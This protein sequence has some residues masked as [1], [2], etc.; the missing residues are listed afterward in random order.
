MMFRPKPLFINAFILSSLAASVY[1]GWRVADAAWPSPWLGTLLACMAPLFFFMRLFLL[2]TPRTSRNLAP[3]LI[4]GVM[5][6][7]LAL[8]WGGPF[9]ASVAALVGIGGSLA[10][11][12]W[13][14]RFE[15]AVA[16]PLRV[17]GSLPE[18][19]LYDV[20]GQEIAARSLL[21]RPALWLF[22]RGNWCPF[23]MAQVR[24]IAGHYRELAQRGIRIVLISPQPEAN[25]RALAERFEVPM[26]FLV[27]RDNAVAR[28]LGVLDEGG[29]P[30]GLQVLGY[31]SDAPRPTVFLTAAGGGILYSDLVENYR[32]RPEPAD[33]LAAFDRAAPRSAAARV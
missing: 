22:Y 23:C 33:F 19:V 29:L 26:Q 24:E 6:A 27:D 2:P 7:G 14:S 32:I 5:G 9:A 21:D 28:K 20:E 18:F 3:L 25:T 8:Y 15:P 31:D 30:A 11:I 1:A 10:Y 17:G 13:Y 4:A 16:T 12:F